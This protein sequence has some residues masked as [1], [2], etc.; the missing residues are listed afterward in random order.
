MAERGVP[1]VRGAEA[2]RVTRIP[3]SGREAVRATTEPKGKGPAN[4]SPP[5]PLPEVAC[6]RLS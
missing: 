5:G 1:A 4:P 6:L 2:Q 3:G